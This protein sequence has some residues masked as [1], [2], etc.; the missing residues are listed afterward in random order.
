RRSRRASVRGVER[1]RPAR[2]ARRTAPPRLE[3]VAHPGRHR[4]SPAGDRPGGRLGAEPPGRVKGRYL[5]FLAIGP[6]GTPDAAVGGGRHGLPPRGGPPAREQCAVP[7]GAPA[8]GGRLRRR[9]GPP[10]LSGSLL[11]FTGRRPAV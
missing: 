4:P 10:R 1:P 6:R 11:R 2:L 7:P 5:L 8:G 3:C 9:G